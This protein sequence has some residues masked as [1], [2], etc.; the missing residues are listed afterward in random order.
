MTATNSASSAVAGATGLGLDRLDAHLLLLHAVG[1]P[2][3]ERAWLL[4]HDLDALPDSVSAAFTALVQRRLLGEPLAYLTGNKAFFGLDLH[5]DA[6]VLVPRPDTET[7]VEW[8]L[9][10]LDGLDAPGFKGPICALDLGTGSGAVALAIKHSRPHVQIHAT[11]FSI[12]ALAVAKANAERLH[13]DVQFNQGSWLDADQHCYHLIVSN[14]PYICAGDPHLIDLT[15][16][17]QQALTG[18]VDGLDGIRAIIGQAPAHLHAGGWLLLEHGYDQ[19]AAVQNLLHQG[20]FT[21]GES[22]R[23]LGGVERCSGG[24]KPE[25]AAWAVGLKMASSLPHSLL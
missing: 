20:G 21:E 25:I 1:K 14:P 22:R 5:V 4:A 11:D 15:H 10:V 13:L 18:G 2:A 9:Q 8:A 23:D 7:L 19:V 3:S 24:R 17:P 12:A 16:E 6:R